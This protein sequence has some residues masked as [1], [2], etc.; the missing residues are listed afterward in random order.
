MKN[1]LL[2][3]D[4]IFNNN[5]TTD[6]SQEK[7]PKI[8]LGKANKETKLISLKRLKGLYGLVKHSPPLASE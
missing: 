6:A 2:Q 4:L 1:I 8:F 7:K 3:K 5:I